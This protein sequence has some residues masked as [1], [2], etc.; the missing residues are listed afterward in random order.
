MFLITYYGKKKSTGQIIDLLSLYLL[1]FLE[2]A[3]RET[4]HFLE[5]V[6]QVSQVAVVELD[7]NFTQGQFVV[8]Q[9]FFCFFY[10]L[11]NEIMLDGD[12]FGFRKKVAQSAV[13]LF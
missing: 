13:I 9:Q 12:A 7:G 10:F 1:Q 6:A 3:G 11:G 8:E 2:L 4:R 5:L